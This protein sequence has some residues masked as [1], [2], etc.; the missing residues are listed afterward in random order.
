MSLFVASLAFE[1]GGT[2]YPGIDRLGILLGSLAAG[3]LGYLV[4]RAVLA[5][6]T[7]APGGGDRV[8]GKVA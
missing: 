4:L 2:A 3:L 5:R 7:G 6:E 1:Q 8:G